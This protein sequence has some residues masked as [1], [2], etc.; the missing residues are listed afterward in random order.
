MW[1]QTKPY[2]FNADVQAGDT[3]AVVNGAITQPFHLDRFTA[4]VSM[5]AGRPC[6]T[7]IS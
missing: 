4:Q 5:S 1:I 6:R 3:H 7:S 2:D